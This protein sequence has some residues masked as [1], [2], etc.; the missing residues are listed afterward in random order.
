MIGVMTDDTTK[1]DQRR[2]LAGR[3]FRDELNLQGLVLNNTAPAQVGLGRNT[4]IRI[5]NGDPSITPRTLLKATIGA[6]L[7]FHFLDYVIEGNVNAI[8][9]LPDLR[10]DLR[11]FTLEE[12]R[13]IEGN[14]GNDST[15]AKRSRAR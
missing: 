12:M 10:E 14:P 9:A 6:R 3:I 2:A 11:H 4:L 7:P 15:R 5:I 13:V 1:Q 8:Q